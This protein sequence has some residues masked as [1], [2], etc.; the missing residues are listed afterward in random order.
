MFLKVVFWS[1]V[2]AN[3]YKGMF[4]VLRVELDSLQCDLLKFQKFQIDETSKRNFV[5]FS[6]IYFNL[7]LKNF[8]FFFPFILN[9]IS[10]NHFQ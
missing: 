1:P 3:N 8:Y 7:S 6:A 2:C 9:E 5:N 4:K 10:P